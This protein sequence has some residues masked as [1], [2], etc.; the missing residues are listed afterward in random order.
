[1]K[2]RMLLGVSPPLKDR[3]INVKRQSGRAAERRDPPRDADV[4]FHANFRRCSLQA[5]EKK[6]KQDGFPDAALNHLSFN[7]N[8]RIKRGFFWRGGAVAALR[9]AE[10]VERISLHN[11]I[12]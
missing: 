4:T 7:C 9:A 12:C 3:L 6:N 10:E 2:R 11:Q 5:G 1:M 8:W